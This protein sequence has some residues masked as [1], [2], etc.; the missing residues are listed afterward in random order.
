MSAI[1]SRLVRDR[2]DDGV[3]F[4]FKWFASLFQGHVEFNISEAQMFA[5]MNRIITDNQG[6]PLTAAEQADIRTMAII[7][8]GVATKTPP[9]TDERGQQ[10]HYTQILSNV[11]MLLQEGHIPEDEWD[12]QVGLAL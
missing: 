8:G 11:T 7:Y 3:T 1:S 12:R 6:T 5:D 10:S 2:V 9:S 4:P